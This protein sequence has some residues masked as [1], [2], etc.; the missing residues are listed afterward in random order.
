MN[1]DELLDLHSSMSGVNAEMSF[2]L[3]DS[4]ENAHAQLKEQARFAEAVKAFQ[5]QLLHDLESSYASTQTYFHKLIDTL[6]SAVQ[7]VITRITSAAKI[8]ESDV[9]SL[10]NVSTVHVICL[11]GLMLL[12]IYAIPTA[13]SRT[14]RGTSGRF[15]RKYCQEA[16]SLHLV[17]QK[18]GK[19]TGL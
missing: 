17:K 4:V 16:P 10:S 2:V 8:V 15:S 6:D 7:T 14:C 12:R 13:K 9:H 19:S 18:T 1:S 5:T 3:A 11:H